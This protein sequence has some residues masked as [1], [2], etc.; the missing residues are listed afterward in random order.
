[1][2]IQ[3]PGAGAIEFPL[4]RVD[5]A[6]SELDL[7]QAARSGNREA[8]RELYARYS[9]MVNAIALA[10]ARPA[11]AADLV[12][13]VF[14][15]AL[16]KL[17]ALRDAGAFGGWLAM[18]ARNCARSHWRA[19]LKAVADPEPTTAP[20]EEDE[21]EAADALEAIRALPEAYR[22]TLLMRLVEGL[23]GPE[24]ARRT[25]LTEGSV[26]V[27]LHRGLKMLRERLGER[28]D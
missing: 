8:F 1:M 21:R 2:Y 23:T 24:I 15:R 14:T 3:H 10:H 22:E 19:P 12:Q 13:E 25:G 16:S 9:P 26:R 5:P 28:H 27:N 11:D 17:S 20:I 6:D 18:I 4:I 7:V